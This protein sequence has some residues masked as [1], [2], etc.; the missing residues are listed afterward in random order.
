MP[1]VPRTRAFRCPLV[2]VIA[3]SSMSTPA[4][5]ELVIKKRLLT[6]TAV[7]RLNADPPLKKVAKR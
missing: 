6:Q 7:A 1:C 2:V 3:G 5:E 4:E